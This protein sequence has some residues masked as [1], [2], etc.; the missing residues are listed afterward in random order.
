[1][2]ETLLTIGKLALAGYLTV[3]ALTWLMQ[4]NLIFLPQPLEGDALRAIAAR[5]PRAEEVRLAADGDVS[6]HG[7][8]LKGD[9]HAPLLIYFGGNAEEVSWLLGEARHFAGHALLL[10]NYRGYGGS[11]GKPG[12]NALLADALRV[13]DFGAGRPDVDPAHIVVMGRSLGSA[14][15][16][17]VAARRR[18]AA[19]VLVSPLDSAAELGRHHYPYLPV[20]W[21]LHQRFDPLA[22]APHVDAPLLTIV[23]ERDSVIPVGHSRRLFDAWHGPKSWHEVAGANHNDLSDRP[24]YW[25]AIG[26]FIASV[27]SRSASAPT[28]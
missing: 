10:M 8:L 16:A 13:Y 27:A 21:L 26:E 1:M 19:V 17:H 15:A 4:D 5:H 2:P 28:K 3:I 9:V 6:L 25:Q 12:A 14:M 22:D 7:W 24:I 23:A 20:S 18:V 11:S